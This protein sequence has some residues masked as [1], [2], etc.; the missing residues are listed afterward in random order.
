[1]WLIKTQYGYINPY[2]VESFSVDFNCRNDETF[3]VCLQMRNGELCLIGNYETEYEANDA[4]VTLVNKLTKNG[5]YVIKPDNFRVE[6]LA[7]QPIEELDFSVR[8]FNF[9]K[10]AGINTLGE[11]LNTSEEE[12]R[13]YRNCGTKSF[14]EIKSKLSEMG[15]DWE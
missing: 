10:R 6:K 3:S 9:L 1:M 14:A 11:L 8:T 15:F 13:K 2:A 12:V 5:E 4:L 7:E